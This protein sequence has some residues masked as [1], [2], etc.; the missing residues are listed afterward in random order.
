VAELSKA[1]L[2]GLVEEAVVDAHDDQ[3]QI[4]GFYYD[5]K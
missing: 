5:R 2:N 1:E 4:T 3:E